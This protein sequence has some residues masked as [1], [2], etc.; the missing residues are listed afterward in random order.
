[1]NKMGFGF[2]RLPQTGKEMDIDWTLLN[3]M[4]DA[5]LASGGTYFDTAYTYLNGKSEEA[6]KRSVVERYPRHQFQI[7]DKLPSWK[8]ASHQDCYTY[9]TEQLERCGV[10][11]FDVYLLHWL[12]RENY[13]IAK[14]Y[15]EFAFLHQIKNEGKT[16]RIGF[17]YHDSAALLD[18]IL[19]E[20]PEV[21]IVQL[22][23]NYLDWDSAGI[24]AGKCYEIAA[25]HDKSIVVMEPVKGG[26]LAALPAEAENLLCN[27]QKESSAASWALRFAQSLEQVEI[28]LSGMNTLEQITDNMKDVSPL[29]QEEREILVQAAKIIR[30]QTAIPCTGCRYCMEYCQKDIPIPDYFS[31]YNE[32]WRHPEDDWKIRPVYNEVATAHGKA[33]E[34]IGCRNCERHCPQKLKISRFLQDVSVKFE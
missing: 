4:T 30:E 11:Y 2:L 3:K 17:S 22:Q 32:L 29:S 12:N 34:C 25:K 9:F 19:A 23:I 14:R 21:D 7:A 15:G 18:Q 27:N 13:E 6:I 31:M 16:K 20:H 28:V 26:T 8:I 10:E 5:F 24:E 33:S 1:M